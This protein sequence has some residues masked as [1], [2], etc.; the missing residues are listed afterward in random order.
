MKIFPEKIIPWVLNLVL[1]SILLTFNLTFGETNSDPDDYIDYQANFET[2]LDSESND[3]YNSGTY[4]DYTVSYDYD[5][6]N[7]YGYGYPISNSWSQSLT[8][9]EVTIWGNTYYLYYPHAIIN[10]GIDNWYENNNWMT[11]ITTGYPISQDDWVDYRRLNIMINYPLMH[12]KSDIGID[13]SNY[14][15]SRQNSL[16]DISGWFPLDPLIKECLKIGLHSF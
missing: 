13:F 3:D 2:T 10:P 9:K 6:I 5:Y 15:Q 1:V 7:T 14:I 12:G 11:S 4:T 8:P 16:V